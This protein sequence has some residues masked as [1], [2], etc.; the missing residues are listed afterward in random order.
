MKK[1]KTLAVMAMGIGL[2]VGCFPKASEVIRSLP[3]ENKKQILAKYSPEQIETGE[4]L[5][6]NN[7]AKCHKL[8]AAEGHTPEQW[9][10]ILKRMIPKAKL[11]DEDGQLVRAYII[12]NAKQ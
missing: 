10:S 1:L 9:N 8:K 5:F 6:A 12:V 11:N 7:C 2:L 3:V 4:T